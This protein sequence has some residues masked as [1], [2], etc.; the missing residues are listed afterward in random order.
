MF[1]ALDSKACFVAPELQSRLRILI[2]VLLSPRKSKAKCQYQFLSW[3]P[4]I[5]SRRRR[6]E[7]NVLHSSGAYVLLPICILQENLDWADL[8]TIDLSLFGT[9]E[10]KQQLAKALVKAVHEDGF[11][12][13]KNFDIPQERV[14]RQFSLGKQFYEIPLEEKLQYVPT[15][16]GMSFRAHILT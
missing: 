3:A 7:K 2:F 5:L 16:L 15:G 12:Y 8:V 6:Y 9:P 1:I 14:N 10:G 13:V 4:S 11:F